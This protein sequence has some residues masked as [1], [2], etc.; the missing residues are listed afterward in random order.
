MVFLGTILGCQDGSLFKK[1]PKHVTKKDLVDPTKTDPLESTMA[2]ALQCKKELELPEAPLQPWNCMAGKEVP[3]TIG[4]ESLNDTNFPLLVQ[5]KVSCDRPS[6]LIPEEACINYSFVQER[7]LTPDTK[8]ALICRTRR[9]VS[10]RNQAE[11]LKDF[12]DTKTITSLLNYYQIETVGLI[13]A[14]MKTGKTCFFDYRS[15]YG[16]YI[17]SPDDPR[18]PSFEDLPEPKLKKDANGLEF[19]ENYWANPTTS[20]WK[21]PQFVTATDQCIR[22]H[23][24]GPFLTSPWLQQ[25][26]TPPRLSKETP[27][28]VV[29]D[30]FGDRQELLPLLAV[31]TTPL[32]AADGKESPQF[33]T[34]CHYIGKNISCS[35]FVPYSVGLKSPVKDLNHPATPAPLPPIWMPPNLADSLKSRGVWDQ[36][37]GAHLKRLLC[38]CNN[39]SAINCTAVDLAKLPQVQ[40]TKGLG[41]DVCP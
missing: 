4:G 14:N 35:H 26:Y 18:K 21:S 39:P 6:W 27:Y 2:Y 24:T 16:G 15:T 38:C 9:F 25:V 13:W 22:C 29:S 23:D 33:C 30:L 36:Q 31:S 41:P 19:S 11:R 20:Q 34:S 8:A 37:Y 32:P 12:L 10:P 3:I 28:L 40:E 17:P 7:T 1:N 5:G